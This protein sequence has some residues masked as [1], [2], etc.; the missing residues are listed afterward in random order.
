[1]RGDVSRRP[2]PLADFEQRIRAL[3]GN[4]Q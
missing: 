1:V 4:A 2:L 3:A